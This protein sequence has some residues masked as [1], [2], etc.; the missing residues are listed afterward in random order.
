V[1]IIDFDG[2]VDDRRA[3]FTAATPD[4]LKSRVFLLGANDDPEALKRSLNIAYEKIGERLAADCD[5]NSAGCWSD[6]QLLHNEPERQRLLM[7][8]KPFLFAP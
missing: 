7:T 2:C 6:S 1:L 8:V 4:D 5:A 3:Q